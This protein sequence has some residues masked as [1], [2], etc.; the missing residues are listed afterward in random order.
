[1]AASGSVYCAPNRRTQ[2]LISCQAARRTVM[3]SCWV[4]LYASSGSTTSA[5]LWIAGSGPSAGSASA[6]P[7]PAAHATIGR[8]VAKSVIVQNARLAQVLTELPYCSQVSRCDIQEFWREL[9]RSFIALPTNDVLLWKPREA[10]PKLGFSK[11]L[12]QQLLKP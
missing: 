1:M 9:A 7:A 10:P 5:G 4:R 11:I 6:E 2:S 8:L 3:Y 12:F